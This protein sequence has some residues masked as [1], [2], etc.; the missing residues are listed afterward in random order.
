MASNGIS[1][2]NNTGKIRQMEATMYGLNIIPYCDEVI[3]NHE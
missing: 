2:T 3:S 1:A